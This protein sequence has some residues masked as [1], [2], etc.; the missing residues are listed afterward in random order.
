MALVDKA[1]LMKTLR[2]VA[3]FDSAASPFIGT[4]LA[5]EDKVHVYRSSNIGFIQSKEVL[6]GPQTFVSLN[7]LQDCLRVLV[8]DKIEFSTDKNGILKVSATDASFETELRVHTV[9]AEKSG[10][11]SHEVGAVKVRL[12]P[13]LFKGFNARHFACATPPVLFNG[14]IMLPTQAGIVFFNCP[15]ELKKIEVNPRESFLN[16]ITPGKTEEIVITEKGYWGAIG[17]DLML[18]AATH[19]FGRPLFNSYQISGELIEVFPVSRLLYSLGAAANLTDS[20]MAKVEIG[21]IDGITTRDN[22]GNPSRFTLGTKGTWLKFNI[23]AKTARLIVDALEQAKDGGDE[24]RLF[25][26]EAG[27]RLQRGCWEVNFKTF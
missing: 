1:E 24:A 14:R 10:Q 9:A 15:E 13:E 12:S 21:P 6:P 7:H 2:V 8:G 16:F 22:F 4:K 18:F 23:M 25:Q 26:T 27:M 5:D 19:Q 17:T 20:P 11:K 3:G